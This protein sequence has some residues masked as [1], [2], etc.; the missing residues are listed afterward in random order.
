[1]QLDVY[2]N[3]LPRARRAFPYVVSLQADLA[4]LGRERVIAFLARRTQ[5]GPVGGK[6]MPIVEMSGRE[7]VL[8]MPS[9]TNVP[10]SELRVPVG[11]LAP[12]RDRIVSAIDWMF[13]GI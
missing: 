13:L 3:P 2:A 9:I 8:L 6:L 1:M 4:A 10:A 7:F 11:N 5:I 12:F